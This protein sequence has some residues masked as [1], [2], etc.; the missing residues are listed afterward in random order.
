MLYRKPCGSILEAVGNT[1]LVRLR[2]VVEHLPAEI[3][4]KLEFM[5]PMGSSKDPC[6]LYTS[7]SPRD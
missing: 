2:R 5:N 3:F 1:P 4:A 6:L 7:P